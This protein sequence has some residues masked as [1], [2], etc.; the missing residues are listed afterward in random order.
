MGNGKNEEETKKPLR[1]DENGYP[2]L[3][4]TSNLKRFCHEM[5]DD[6]TEDGDVYEVKMRPTTPFLSKFN[7]TIFQLLIASIQSARSDNRTNMAPEDI[8]D[9]TELE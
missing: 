8:P 9:L 5:V 3:V 1:M 2:M 6:Q 4:I 7:E